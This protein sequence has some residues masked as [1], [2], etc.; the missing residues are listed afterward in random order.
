MLR[1][2]LHPLK[3]TYILNQ[4]LTLKVIFKN[5]GNKTYRLFRYKYFI[6][7]T[8]DIDLVIHFKGIKS[9]KFIG[10]HPMNEYDLDWWPKVPVDVE[11]WKK[12]A[13]IILHPGD[14]VVYYFNLMTCGDAFHYLWVPGEYYFEKIKAKWYCEPYREFI[15]EEVNPLMDYPIWYD[16]L[17]CFMDLRF[18][19]INPEGKIKEMNEL[20]EKARRNFDEEIYTELLKICPDTSLL[21]PNIIAECL[22]LTNAWKRVDRKR[23]YIKKLLLSYKR[24]PW[25]YKKYLK[26]SRLKREICGFGPSFIDSLPEE[27]REEIYE[28]LG[29]KK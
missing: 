25:F 2:E 23:Y 13:P 5:V 21:Y 12:R 6:H 16:T 7:N 1:G 15:K 29:D 28:A 8:E 27:L 14:S 11:E 10:M 24:F 19:V 3:D 22:Q 20:W 26:Y 4:P 17:S 9:G 18:K